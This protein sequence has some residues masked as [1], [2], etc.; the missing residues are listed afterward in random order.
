MRWWRQAQ[1]CTGYAGIV[2]TGR[3]H[4]CCMVLQRVLILQTIVWYVLRVRMLSAYLRDADIGRLSSLGECI[5]PAV[6]VLS[7]L[8]NIA[9][10]ST[11]ASVRYGDIRYHRGPKECTHLQLVLQQI[12]LVR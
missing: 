1:S 11:S 3:A 5:V 6:E 9:K 12:L 4:D 7:L 10:I 2:A 8:V